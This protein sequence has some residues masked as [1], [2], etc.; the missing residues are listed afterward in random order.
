[1]K[2]EEQNQMDTMPTLE[3]SQIRRKRWCFIEKAYAY[4]RECVQ[5]YNIGVYSFNQHDDSYLGDA[6][7]IKKKGDTWNLQSWQEVVRCNEKASLVVW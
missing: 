7:Y 4:R 2:Q 3:V 1:M 5:E 6:F